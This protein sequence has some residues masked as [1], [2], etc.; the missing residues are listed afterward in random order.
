MYFY[1]NK[2]ENQIA[3]SII[4]GIFMVND[5]QVTVHF[6]YTNVELNSLHRVSW[7]FCTHHLSFFHCCTDFML[8]IKMNLFENRYFEFPDKNGRQIEQEIDV[9]DVY[10]EI[11]AF[12]GH[13]MQEEFDSDECPEEMRCLNNILLFVVGE[14]GEF[15]KQVFT[16]VKN[17]SIDFWLFRM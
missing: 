1:I 9:F 4:P 7:K 6:S 14:K 16:D 15:F 13:L 8:T 2:N 3:I 12:A 17:L 10:K 11:C 5:P